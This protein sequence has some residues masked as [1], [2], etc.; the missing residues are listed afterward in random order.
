MTTA[1][2]RLCAQRRDD[3]AAAKTDRPLAELEAAAKAAAPPRGFAAALTAKAAQG[4]AI[5]AELKKAS[6]SA[7]LIRPDFA[8]DSL[9]KAYS[10]GGAACLSVL[11]EP[12]EFLG[13]DA[14]LEQARAATTLP[15]LR[16]DFIVDP[17]QIAESRALAADC[18][19]LI[20]AALPD[21]LAAEMMA[22]AAAWDMDVLVEV[23]TAEEMQRAL[24]LKASLIG[25]NNRDLKSLKVDTNTTP[26]LAAMAP[27]P[28]MIV[29]ESGLKDRA[30]LDTL[31]EAGVCR[32]LIGESLMRQDDVALALSALTEAPAHV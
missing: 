12:H 15:A 6:P 14:Y 1:L 28:A 30:T 9:A 18:I 10:A 32:F 27:D 13:D 16:K 3:V 25:I 5:I 4:H 8:P 20:L 7:G 21:G 24:D 2:D 11:T 19:L 29:A 31:A 22:E 26:R 17:Y 23:H